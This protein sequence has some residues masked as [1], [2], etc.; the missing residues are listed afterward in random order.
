MN[1]KYAWLQVLGNWLR[2]VVEQGTHG[3]APS[4]ALHPR[5]STQDTLHMR[6]NVDQVSWKTQLTD[7][8]PVSEMSGDG[9]SSR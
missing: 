5:S 4:L 2:Q 9:L 6:E 3:S 8:S 1:F 7:V